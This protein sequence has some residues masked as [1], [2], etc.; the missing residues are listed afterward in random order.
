MLAVLSVGLVIRMMLE[1]VASSAAS[2]LSDHLSQILRLI[3]AVK[4][5]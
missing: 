3:V 1:R 5:L 4:E 2:F